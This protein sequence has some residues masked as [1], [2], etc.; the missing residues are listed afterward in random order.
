MDTAE[1]NAIRATARQCW[2]EI[3]AAWKEEE[4]KSIKER[5][6]ISR[7]I[8]TGYERRI[9]PRF[10]LIQLIYNIGLVNGVLKEQL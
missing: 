9:T 7:R 4:A 2:K 1:K 5:E 8:L 6:I 10:T 3:Q